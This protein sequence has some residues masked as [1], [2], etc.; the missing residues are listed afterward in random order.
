MYKQKTKSTEGYD[1][2]T[3]CQ[4][5]NTIDEVD[6]VGDEDNQQHGERNTDEGGNLVDAQ[7]PVEIV[8]VQ[9][10]DGEEGRRDNLNL[11]LI[12][13]TDAY[14]VVANADDVQQRKACKETQHFGGDVYREIAIGQLVDND[15]IHGE[16]ADDKQ[17]DRKKG[18]S[19]QAGYR[20]FVYFTLIGN[21][22]QT[23]AHRNH[24]NLGYDAT[25]HI[26]GN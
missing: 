4:P 21:V 17:D 18:Y 11:E 23:L 3:G 13:V 25:S 12:P 14:Q 1:A 16:D 22:E 9:A 8:D 26:G 6:G 10:C 19:A 7:Q 20:T 15:P 2:D 24:Q 5:V